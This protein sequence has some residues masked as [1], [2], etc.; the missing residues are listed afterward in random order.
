MKF[1]FDSVWIGIGLWAVFSAV[2]TFPWTTHIYRHNVS[3]ATLPADDTALTQWLKTQP[4]VV[5]AVV[6]RDGKVVGI[7]VTEKKLEV[8]KLNPPWADMGYRGPQFLDTFSY[9]TRTTVF[10]LSADTS[11]VIPIVVCI[12]A[13][14]ALNGLVGRWKASSSSG[15][16]S[17]GGKDVSS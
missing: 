13:G 9:E 6:A 8:V 10:D 4:D 5:D 12:L 11:Q 3:F 17:A 15:E 1:L 16:P 2:T 7:V 14:F